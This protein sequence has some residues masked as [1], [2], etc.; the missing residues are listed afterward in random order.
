MVIAVAQAKTTKKPRHPRVPL[1]R[2]RGGAHEDK[3]KRPFR[4][5]KHPKRDREQDRNLLDD[6][7]AVSRQR[8]LWT[9]AGPEHKRLY[10]VRASLR[11]AKGDRY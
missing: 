8:R 11:V 9:R 1:P 4:E 3:T 6:D 10:R 7:D 2:Q 5:R